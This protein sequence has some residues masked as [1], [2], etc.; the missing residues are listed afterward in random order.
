MI[1][2]NYILSLLAVLLL[3]SCKSDPHL[4]AGKYPLETKQFNAYLQQN[5]STTIPG[6]NNCYVLIS[7]S[8]CGGCVKTFIRSLTIAAKNNNVHYILPN[9]LLTKQDID[10]GKLNGAVMID[11]ENKVDRLP[12]HKGNIAIV[13][14]AKGEITNY[15][16]VEPY[17]TDSVLRILAKK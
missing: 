11:K 16:N 4:A 10:E 9:K 2:R 14:T 8:G 12:Y 15:Y 3:F 1:Y 7:S 5:F 6:G 13:E 17:Q